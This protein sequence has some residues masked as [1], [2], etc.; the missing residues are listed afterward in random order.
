MIRVGVIGCGRWGLE[1]LTGYERVEDASVVAVCDVD[2]E[3]AERAAA[4]YGAAHWYTD[5]R[6]MLHRHEFDL[7][8]VCTLPASHRDITVDAFAAGANVLCEKPLAMNLDEAKEM[9]AAAERAGKFLTVGYENRFSE[10]AQYLKRFVADGKMGRPV[11]TRCWLYC[12]F[13]W[14]GR[15]YNIMSSLCGGGTVTS[16]GI[17]ALDLAMWVAGYPTPTTVSATMAQTF[18]RKRRASAPSAETVDIYD[19]EDL[20][21]AHIRFADGSWM[22][23]ESA[24]GGIDAFDPDPRAFSMNTTLSFMMAGEDATIEFAPLHVLV[25]DENGAIVDATP[26]DVPTWDIPRAMLAEIAEV[27]AAVREGRSPVVRSDQA[28]VL[29]QI[30]DAIYRSARAG[31]EVKVAPIGDLADVAI[32][33]SGLLSEGT[34]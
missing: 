24:A 30:R 28:L 29:E 20:A 19:V 18:P 34:V 8:S 13:P 6:E 26:T 25:N 17:H 31:A 32:R 2:P 33:P 23:L 11:Y 7:V 27:V 3:A 14:W 4:R 5:H 1:H 22:T 15:A 10:S 12:E 16:G 21:S 9:A